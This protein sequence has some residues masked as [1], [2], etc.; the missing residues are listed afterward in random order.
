LRK[1]EG[2]KKPST[3][4]KDDPQRRWCGNM[5]K[6]GTK[7]SRKLRMGEFSTLQW[8]RKKKTG[9]GRKGKLGTTLN[10]G[11]NLLTVNRALTATGGEGSQ[12]KAT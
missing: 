1:S 3:A 4:V 7:E 2:E 5:P 10:V 12:K 6:V 11:G 9:N 8:Q